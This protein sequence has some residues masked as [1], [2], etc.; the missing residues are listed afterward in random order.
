MDHDDP[1]TDDTVAGS[2]PDPKIIGQL[3]GCEYRSMVIR[4]LQVTVEWQQTEWLDLAVCRPTGTATRDDCR[5]CPVRAPCLTA[6]LVLDD[7]ANWR[8]GLNPAQRQALWN[9]LEHTFHQLRDQDFMQ[10]DRL[11]DGH[12]YG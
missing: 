12:S 3:V 11:V 7:H 9:R 10:L 6:A 8:G 4:Q 2:A 5:G 1:D